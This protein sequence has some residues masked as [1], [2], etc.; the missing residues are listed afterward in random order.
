MPVIKLAFLDVGQGDT[1]IITSPDTH[2][3]IVV[4]CID[5]EAVLTYLEKEQITQL[6]G[7]IITHLHVDHYKETADLLYSY[8]KGGGTLDCEVL[9]TTESVVDP[10]YLKRINNSKKRVNSPNQWL[11][12][13]DGHSTVLEQPPPGSKNSLS[14]RSALAKLYN[15]CQDNDKK[16]KLI[17]ADSNILLPL[18]GD[19]AQS[20]EVL[21]PT[22]FD[23]PRLKRS[24]SGLNNIS[25]VLRVTGTGTSA[26]LTGDLEPLGWQSLKNQYPELKSDVLKFPHHGGAWN[27]DEANDLLSVVQPSVVAI[28]VGS[29]NDYDHP[30][31]DVF[32][33]LQKRRDLRLLCTQATEKC[34]TSLQSVRDKVILQFEEQSRKNNSFFLSPTKNQCPCSGS[35]IIELR[36]TPFVIQPNIDFHESLINTHF[37][38]HKCVLRMAATMIGGEALTSNLDL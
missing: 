24:K 30:Y 37:K 3:A 32:A 15:W 14:L 18:Q 2:E 19:I 21:H 13:G 20:L 6:R 38:E 22:F 5:S 10:A 29:N 1:T 23:Y 16:C 34:R 27:E 28:S 12:D 35:V 33:A 9:A 11:P 25:V 7:V 4:D 36:D 8:E 17:M 26:L 31:L